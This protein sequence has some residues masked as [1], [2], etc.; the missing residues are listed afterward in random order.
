[1]RQHAPQPKQKK[2]MRIY[3]DP[4]VNKIVVNKKQSTSQS[5]LV[6]VLLLRV[7][8][9]PRVPLEEHQLPSLLRRPDVC[10]CIHMYVSPYD[11]CYVSPIYIYMYACQWLY[12]GQCPVRWCV[13]ACMYVITS[14]IHLYKSTR[15]RLRR[16]TGTKQARKEHDTQTRAHR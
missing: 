6:V 11:D 9:V 8:L 12:T 16:R 1:M 3:P 10:G 14:V 7:R 5:L 4:V 13:N 2:S 15:R